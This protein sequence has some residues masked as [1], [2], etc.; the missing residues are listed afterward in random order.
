MEAILVLDSFISNG[1]NGFK[2]L[3]VTFCSQLRFDLGQNVKPMK[4]GVV[5]YKAFYASQL[6]EFT[7]KHPFTIRAAKRG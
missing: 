2:H 1:F 4:N 3:Y 6:I 7:C 5:Y